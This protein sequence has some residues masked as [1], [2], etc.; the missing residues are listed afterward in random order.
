MRKSRKAA[1]K[2]WFLASIMKEELEFAHTFLKGSQT[3]VPP[4]WV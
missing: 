1:W 2:K 4:T 3:L